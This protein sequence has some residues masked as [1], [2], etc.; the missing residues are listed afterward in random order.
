MIYQATVKDVP[1][2]IPCAAEYTD[3]IP[4]MKFNP[5]HYV[6]FWQNM[7]KSGLGVIFLSEVDGVVLGGIGGIKF[8]EAL[9]GRMTAVEMFW[10]TAKET[11]GDGVKLYLKFKK[12]AKENGCERLAMIYLPCS[13]PDKL[14]AFYDKEGF[15]LI[16]MHYEMAL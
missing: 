5:D 8:P 10:Y 4:D 16:E 7:L 1:K 13:M 3:I 9:S 15:S 11:R 6:Q 2:I 12:W 14:K